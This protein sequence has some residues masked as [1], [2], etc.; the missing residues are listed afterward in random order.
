MRIP[1]WLQILLILCFM[2]MPMLS[3]PMFFEEGRGF[4]GPLLRVIIVYALFVVFFYVHYYLLL[5]R[6]Y[7]RGRYVAYVCIVLLSFITILEI[8][9][10]FRVFAPEHVHS[11]P[12]HGHELKRGLHHRP[13]FWTEYPRHFFLFV[14]TVL[15]G[16]FIRTNERLVAAK[17]GKTQA[18]LSYLKAQ[19]NPH[20]LF[21]TLNSIYSLSLTKSEKTPDA[22][23]QLSGMMRHVLV[24]SQTDRVPL[25]KELTYVRNYIE[26]QKLRLDEEVSLRFSESCVSTGKE[27]AP[28]LL[29][30]FIENAFKY[31]VNSE[32]MSDINIE[33]KTEGDLL[34]MNVRNRK[35]D[36]GISA[37]ERTGMGLE[38]ARNRLKLLYPDRH[39]LKID[40]D[41]D[42]F[43]VTLTIKLK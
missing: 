22:V 7:Y 36:V 43:A 29:I 39:L 20:F 40:E 3:S 33:I 42:T 35:V 32:Q 37:N 13:P 1:V 19:I 17:Q 41:S 31:G 6:F 4:Q 30:P 14:S 10:L 38:N 11:L 5:D 34:T 21:N 15:L 23:V 28:L 12:P 9:E 24:D 2:A 27:I 26:L 8:P 16:H 25:E 18:E